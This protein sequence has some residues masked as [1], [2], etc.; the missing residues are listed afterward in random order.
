MSINM[1]KEIGKAVNFMMDNNLGTPQM[2]WQR[3]VKIKASD[4]YRNQSFVN[5]H[6][7]Y[8]GML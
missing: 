1:R 4:E 2:D 6:P 8:Q 3:K 5:V 7:E